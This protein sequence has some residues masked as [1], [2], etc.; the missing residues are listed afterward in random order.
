LY[1][2]HEVEPFTQRFWEA[3]QGWREA[4]KA[5]RAALAAAPRKSARASVKKT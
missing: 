5:E 3:I 1:P 2:A 4:D